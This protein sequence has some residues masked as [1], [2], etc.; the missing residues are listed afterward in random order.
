MMLFDV[1]RAI[2]DKLAR[3]ANNN[4]PGK[5]NPLLTATTDGYT[6]IIQFM[7]ETVWDSSE[8]VTNDYNSEEEETKRVQ[9]HIETKIQMVISNLAGFSAS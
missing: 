8:W 3:R 5:R 1:V 9:A 6:V 4:R 7:T 2:N